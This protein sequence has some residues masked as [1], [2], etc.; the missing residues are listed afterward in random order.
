MYESERIQNEMI[1]RLWEPP[2][3]SYPFGLEFF[4]EMTVKKYRADTI[5]N[6]ILTNYKL[7]ARVGALRQRQSLTVFDTRADPSI[8]WETSYPP[9]TNSTPSCNSTTAIFENNKNCTGL[10]WQQMF[11]SIHGAPRLRERACEANNTSART[12]AVFCKKI[13]RIRWIGCLRSTYEVTRIQVHIVVKDRFSKLTTEMPLKH[14]T[15]L[16]VARSLV[17]NCIP[18]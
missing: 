8:I 7:Q 16:N 15:A 3:R 4:P 11:G 12:V 13:T 14:I 10:V 6:L 1:P 17:K 9:S 5:C 18:C 2:R